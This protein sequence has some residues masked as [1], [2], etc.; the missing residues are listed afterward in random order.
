MKKKLLTLSLVSFMFIPIV[1]SKVTLKNENDKDL[2][3]SQVVKLKS[4]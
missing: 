3:L 1:N 2:A 4:E